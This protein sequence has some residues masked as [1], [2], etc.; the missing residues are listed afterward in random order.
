LL[1]TTEGTT[2]TFSGLDD[3]SYRLSETTTPAGYN[4]IDDVYFTV[5]AD[6]D[7]TSDN[8]ALTSLSATQTAADGS[9]LS[10]GVIAT[11]TAVPTDG[12]LT[13]DIVNN[14]GSTLPSTGG[15]GTT[16]FTVAGIVLMI[17]AAVVLVTKRKVSGEDQ[18]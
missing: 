2:F 15:I 4:T 16:I 18:K 11:F 1:R 5:S 7:I 12:S 9:S 8:P 14:S 17:G 3:G 13:T 6:H 10:T